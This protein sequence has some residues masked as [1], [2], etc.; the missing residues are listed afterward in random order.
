[1][2]YKQYI[3]DFKKFLLVSFRPT[4]QPSSDWDPFIYPPLCLSVPEALWFTWFLGS[5]GQCLTT[6]C[7]LITIDNSRQPKCTHPAGWKQDIDV[8]QRNRGKRHRGHRRKQGWTRQLL[9]LLVRFIS[10]SGEIKSQWKKERKH[11]LWPDAQWETSCYR[12]KQQ[13]SSMS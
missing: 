12:Q 5:R 4:K 3:L 7:L 8:S 6:G 9:Y 10:S 2:D 11:P 13:Q 1:M